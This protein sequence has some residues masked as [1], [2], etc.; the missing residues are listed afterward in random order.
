ML[1]GPRIGADTADS[2]MGRSG[3]RIEGMKDMPFEIHLL[4]D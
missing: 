2:A 4:I 1:A 3:E